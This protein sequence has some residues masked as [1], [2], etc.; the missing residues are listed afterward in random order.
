MG[1]NGNAEARDNAMPFIGKARPKGKANRKGKANA[2]GKAHGQSQAT[3][4]EPLLFALPSGEA[5]GPQSW[6]TQQN[7]ELHPTK[8]TH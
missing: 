7:M 5:T 2:Q 4:Q 8:P 6:Q 3:P 1:A